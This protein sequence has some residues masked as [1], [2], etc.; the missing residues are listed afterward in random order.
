MGLQRLINKCHTCQFDHSNQVIAW[1]LRNLDYRIFLS[2]TIYHC[3][4]KLS[5]SYVVVLKVE[6]VAW[7]LEILFACWSF[8]SCS[9]LVY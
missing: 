1:F 2:F 6:M 3:K 5:N 7:Y 8:G 4:L 9:L